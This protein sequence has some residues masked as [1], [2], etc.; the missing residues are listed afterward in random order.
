MS[1][2]NYRELWQQLKTVV[3]FG[4]KSRYTRRELHEMMSFMELAQL[5]QDPFKEMLEPVKETKLE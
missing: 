4:G 1:K 5:A 2:R 3:L